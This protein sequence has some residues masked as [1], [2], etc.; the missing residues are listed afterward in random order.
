MVDQGWVNWESHADI[1]KANERQKGSERK[2]KKK[3]IWVYL[4][5]HFVG[6][7]A[8]LNEWG[9]GDSREPLQRCIWVGRLC[10]ACLKGQAN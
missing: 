10:L 6:G 5:L 2:W 9:S 4:W 8:Y 1:A 7:D 3:K